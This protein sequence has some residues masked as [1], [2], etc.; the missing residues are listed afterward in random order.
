VVSGGP[1]SSSV[2]ATVSLPILYPSDLSSTLHVT[3]VT[4]G[5]VS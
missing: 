4:A 3:L 2:G 1:K 5:D